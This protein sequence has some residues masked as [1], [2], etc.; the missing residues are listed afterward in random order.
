MDELS[1]ANVNADMGYAPP[2]GSVFEENQ[3]ARLEFGTGDRFAHPK[4]FGCRVGCVDA[5]TA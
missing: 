5:M 2:S 1:I 4:Q 3:I